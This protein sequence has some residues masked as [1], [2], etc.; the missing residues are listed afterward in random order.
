MYRNSALIRCA[1][2]LLALLL[3]SG[4]SSAAT[5]IATGV[6]WSRGGTIWIDANGT[7]EQ[8][9]AGVIL[10]TLNENGQPYDRNTLCVDLF[11]DINEDQTYGSTVLS[12]SDVPGKNLNRVSWLI[13][14]ALLPTE[15]SAPS[16]PSALP[17]ADWVTNSAQGAGIQLAI[18]DIVHDG[19]DGF[20]SGLVQA[21]TDPNNPTD[22]TVL[23]WAQ[24]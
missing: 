10:I 4:L 21:S 6:D 9:I 8:A 15:P 1:G 14:N 17:Q 23:G 16:V 12:P 7:N 3:S 13:D 24:T 5:I 2:L 19:G 22:P 18:W 20:S 11:T